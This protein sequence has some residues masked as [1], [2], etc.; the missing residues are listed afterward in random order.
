MDRC[1]A[2]LTA[3]VAPH[4]PP[5]RSFPAR[6]WDTPWSPPRETP[7]GGWQDLPRAQTPKPSVGAQSPGVQRREAWR[8]LVT[9]PMEA[10]MPQ[11]PQKRQGLPRDALP[12]PSHACNSLPPSFP[13]LPPFFPS[14]FLPFSFCCCDF[15]FFFSWY[16]QWQFSFIAYLSFPFSFTCTHNSV[17]TLFAILS[18]QFSLYFFL[19]CFPLHTLSPCSAISDIL[20][21]PYWLFWKALF[22][23]VKFF[24]SLSNLV[25][26]C[27]YHWE[28]MLYFI[29]LTF[30]FFSKVSLFS[31]PYHSF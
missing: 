21:L 13:S 25:P 2:S 29:F 8:I 28:V 24:L 26:K 5:G 14:S 12:I 22:Y 17:Y 10:Q 19:S 9:C 23:F 6:I 27:F 7:A 20:S 15:R 4:T 31:G 16:L 1:G 3:L 11:K 18:N 30:C